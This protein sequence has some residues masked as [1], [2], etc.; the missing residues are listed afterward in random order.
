MTIRKVESG[1][2]KSSGIR[3]RSEAADAGFLIAAMVQEVF[4]LKS[5]L[6]VECIADSLSLTEFLKNIACHSGHTSSSGC[7]TNQR[8]ATVER[9]KGEVG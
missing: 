1:D 2:E 9:D 7:S 3:N 5:P 8:D 4:A 6:A